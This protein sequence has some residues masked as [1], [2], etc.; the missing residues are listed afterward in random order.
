MKLISFLKNFKDEEICRKIDFLKKNKLFDKIPRRD[1][2]YVLEA[3]QERTYVKGETV[4]SEGDIGRALF[5]VMAGKIDLLKKMPDGSQKK[6]ASINPGEFFG[7]MSLIEELPR[8][9]SAIVSEDASMFLLFKVKL[10]SMLYSR[11]SIGVHIS[12]RLAKIISA[13]LRDMLKDM[14]IRDSGNDSQK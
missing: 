5:M 4:F 9:T 6:V 10:D 3:L 1:L 14:E 13:R 7:E 2:I 8:T 12:T 11:P